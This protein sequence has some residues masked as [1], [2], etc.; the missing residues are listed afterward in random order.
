M[1]YLMFKMIHSIN[2]KALDLVISNWSICLVSLVGNLSADM[3]CI[4]HRSP[5]HDVLQ[6]LVRSVC[7]YILLRSHSNISATL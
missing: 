5:S 4:L 3:S 2:L 1:S 7:M 6:S